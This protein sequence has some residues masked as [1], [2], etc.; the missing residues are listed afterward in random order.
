MSAD[1]LLEL[2]NVVTSFRINDQFYPAVDR[3]SLS[4]ERNEVL[5]LVGESGSGK[6]ALAFS[7]M[8]LHNTLN[9]KIEGKIRLEGNEISQ[10]PSSK[11]N[12]IRGKD[13]GM[14]FQEPLTALNPLKTIGDQII[15]TLDLHTDL[16]KNKKYER[17]I[18]L[19]NEVGIPKPE[20]IYRQY[21]HELSGGMR[22]RIVIAIAIANNPSLLIADE[23]T[24]ALDATIQS[25][26]LDL[27]NELKRKQDSGIILITHDLGVVAEMA[28]RVAVMYAGEIVELTDV[29]SLFKRPL[30]PYTRSLLSSI[31][32]TTEK[33]E[34]L[35][36]I[37][38]IVPSLQHIPREG[39][40][41]KY[42]IP[43][44]SEEAHE[45]S[46]QLREV[47]PGHFV[48]CTCY[49]HF[50]F[51]EEREEDHVATEGQ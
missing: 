18:Q 46:P 6:S 31:P 1:S 45:A 28:D 24:T 3:V 12:K 42:R 34:K 14:I 7:I 40:R 20:N 35:E 43:W 2:E 9:T 50:Y 19:L 30:H 49:K 26:I 25:Q 15:E 38:G 36:V 22:Q 13:I 23:P 44:I 29:Y 5:A 10:L 37:Q 32:S 4:L 27:L 21:P 8:G 11:F 17:C 33:K 16:P 39:C 51:Q 47:H 48:R 41:F